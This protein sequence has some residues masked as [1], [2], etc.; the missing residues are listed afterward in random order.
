MLNQ[1]VAVPSI[2]HC[3]WLVPNQY[4][5]MFTELVTLVRN[6]EVLSSRVLSVFSQ[7]YLFS[8]VIVAVSREIFIIVCISIHMII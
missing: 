5:A 6:I 8:C 4:K 1:S 2:I 3:M 7:K